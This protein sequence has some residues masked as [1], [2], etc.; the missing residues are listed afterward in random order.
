M[1]PNIKQKTMGGSDSKVEEEKTD[2]NE[3]INQISP[4]AFTSI[5]V[6]GSSVLTSIVVLLVILAFFFLMYLVL[7]RYGCCTSRTRGDFEPGTEGY[8]RA[9]SWYGSVWPQNRGLFDQNIEFGSMPI[10]EYDRSSRHLRHVDRA[11]Y[12]NGP[13]HVLP[14]TGP[15][16]MLPIKYDYANSASTT[17]NPPIIIQTAGP[18]HRSTP[19][20]EREYPSDRFLP[21]EAREIRDSI[22]EARKEGFERLQEELDK[23]KEDR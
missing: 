6:H 8:R 3:V 18:S 13:S 12:L 1:E 2:E 19:H 15:P 5:D 20:R 17:T 10:E 7:K 4:R 21:K 22:L 23:M 16:P 9:N 14:I 11:R